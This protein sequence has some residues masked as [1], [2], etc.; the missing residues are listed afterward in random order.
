MK[1]W[2][3]DDLSLFGAQSH[4]LGTSC[5][6]FVPPSRTT[7]QDSLAGGTPRRHR[8][9]RGLAFPARDFIPTFAGAATRRV[10]IECFSFDMFYVISLHPH[11]LSFD[12]ATTTVTILGMVLGISYGGGLIIRDV[13]SGRLSAKDVFFSMSLMGLS[14]AIVEDT[15]LMMSLGGNITGLLLAR[16]GFTWLVIACLVRIV[17]RMPDRI[18]YRYLFRPADQPESIRR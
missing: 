10:P 13:S 3:Q 14:H 16:V 11:S 1:R 2:T 4:G 15:F 7:T 12:G 8:R 6:R 18:F 5:L 9:A 17:N